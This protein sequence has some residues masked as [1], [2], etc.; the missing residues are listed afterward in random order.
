MKA[1]TSGLLGGWKRHRRENDHQTFSG[2][3]LRAVPHIFTAQA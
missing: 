2:M 3:T 1:G